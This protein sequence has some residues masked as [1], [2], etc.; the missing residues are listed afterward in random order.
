MILSYIFIFQ[1]HLLNRSNY[2]FNFCIIL[3]KSLINFFI[4][5]KNSVKFH[6]NK[7]NSTFLTT[8]KNNSTFY[9]IF[10]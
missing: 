10:G 5:L 8:K 7:N 1:L 2:T 3:L 9:F 4:Q 6:Y